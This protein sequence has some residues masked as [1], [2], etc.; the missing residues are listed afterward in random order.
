MRELGERTGPVG[1]RADWQPT[2]V[3]LLSVRPFGFGIS[4]KRILL[5]VTSS[6]IGE[7]VLLSVDVVSNDE[8]ESLRGAVK[9]S[10]G[11]GE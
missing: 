10:A 3:L 7:R 8:D 9:W 2:G 4:S 11:G 5:S 6:S 1:W